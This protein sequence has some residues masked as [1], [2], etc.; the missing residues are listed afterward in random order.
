MTTPLR[1]ALQGNR[2]LTVLAGVMSGL[3]LISVAGL[4]ADDR[5]LGGQPIWLKPATFATS[6]VFYGDHGEHA[7]RL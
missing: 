6:F 4:L 5:T 2:A 3:L 7:L 1:T